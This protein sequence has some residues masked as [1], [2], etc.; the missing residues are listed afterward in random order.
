[1]HHILKDGADSIGIAGASLRVY[2]NIGMCAR[3][4]D[5]AARSDIG[6]KKAQEPFDM[7]PRASKCEDWRDTEAR[8][9]AA[10]AFLKT[11]APPRL[12]DAPGGA[13]V[14]DSAGGRVLRRGGA[15]FADKCA[16]CHSSKQPPAGIAGPPARP[17]GIASRCSLRTS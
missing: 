8:M 11:L 5:D 1:M 3:L 12:A 17:R 4:L 7:D 6:V 16:Q 14:S 9:P 15:A 2:V 13:G 10:E